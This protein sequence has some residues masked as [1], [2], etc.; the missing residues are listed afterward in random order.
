MR[1]KM[2]LNQQPKN[3][4]TV[5]LYSKGKINLPNDVKEDLH[6]Q[7]GD[8]VILIKN[9]NSWTITTRNALIKDAQQY[10]ATLNPDGESLVD[11]FIAERQETAKTEI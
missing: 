9:N 8:Q 10:A 7:D 4:Y 5:R 11:N 6:V 1:F 3:N 2:S